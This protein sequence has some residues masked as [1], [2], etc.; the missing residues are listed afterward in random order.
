MLQMEKRKVRRGFEPSFDANGIQGLLF[1]S[2]IMEVLD[3][4]LS[5]KI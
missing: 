2:N 4:D 1:V 3:I 5:K